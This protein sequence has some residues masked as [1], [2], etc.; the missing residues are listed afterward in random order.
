[1]KLQKATKIHG[2]W[3]GDACGAA[4]ALELIGERWSLMI[5]RE[6]M[7]GARRFSD[8]RASLPGISA[9][10]LTERLEGLE[11]SGVLLRRKL[12][13]PASGQ[14]YELTEWGY[15]AEPLMQELG[16]WA[17]RSPLHD[18]RLPITPVAA[19]LSLRTMIDRDAARSFDAAI[20]F[21]IGDDRF[22]ARLAH[23][24]L[25]IRRVDRIADDAQLRFTAPSATGLLY[26]FYGKMPLADA[27]REFDLHVEGDAGLAA[28]FIALFHLP[29]KCC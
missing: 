1:M 20:G 9:K 10:V 4:F 3:Y 7:L 17:V 16:R 24:E 14:V 28:R 13:A 8:L 11:A 21:A 29:A 12:P 18:P 5:I 27:E 2:K 6:L 22:D 15:L 26:L 19:M 23:G 25:A